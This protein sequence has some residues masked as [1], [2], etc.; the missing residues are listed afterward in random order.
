MGGQSPQAMNWPVPYA[1]RR[2]DRGYGE[3]RWGDP[4]PAGGDLASPTGLVTLYL[5]LIRRDA[6]VNM[7]ILDK[8]LGRRHPATGELGYFGLTGWWTSSFSPAERDYME[9]AFRTD[10]MPARARP[11]TRDRGL[12]TLTTATALLTLLAERL[13]G[14]PQDRDLAARVLAQ[15]ER[16]ASAEGDVLGLHSVY[17]QMIRLHSRWKDDFPDAVDLTLAA[18]HRQIVLAEEAAKALRQMRPNES[19]P[20]HLGYLWATAILE[21]EGRYERAIELCRQ[22][23]SQGWDGN[24]PWRIQ[25]LTRKLYESRSPVKSISSSGITRL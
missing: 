17:H 4:G 24:W 1:G 3:A 15:A 11:L 5:D 9:A 16:R 19:L 23:Q 14:K 6:W 18:C 8:I 25:C 12:V 13:S 22:A 7:R 21:R 10:E 20:S 2:R